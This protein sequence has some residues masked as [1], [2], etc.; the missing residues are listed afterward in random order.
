MSL[1][2]DLWGGTRGEGDNNHRGV[3]EKGKRKVLNDDGK[4]SFAQV[5]NSS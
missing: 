4:K 3:T 2:C 5:V 1:L